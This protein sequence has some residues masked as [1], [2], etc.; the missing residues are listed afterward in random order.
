VTVYKLPATEALRRLHEFSAIIDAR[1]EG[2]F[3]LDH[4]PDALNWPVLTDE[5]RAAVGTMDRQVGSFEAKKRG[6]AMVARN[7]ARHIDTQVQDLRADWKPLVY[8]W[9]GGKRS[10]TL[11]WFLDQIGFQTHVIEGGYKAFRKALVDD[12]NVLPLKFEFRVVCGKT[13]SGKT[14][15][16]H[17]LERAGAQILDLEGLAHHRGSVL[18]II[19]GKHQPTQKAYDRA[20]WE[21][22]SA[23]DPAVPVFVESESKKV[24]NL[25]VPDTLMQRMR[26][27]GQ[28]LH[29]ELDDDNRVALLLEEYD[30]FRHDVPLFHQRLEAL[31]QIRGREV[32]DAWKAQSATGDFAGVYRDLML[33]HY[34]PVYLTS[35]TRNFKQFGSAMVV[36]PGHHGASAYDAAAREILQ[37]EAAGR[38]SL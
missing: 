5:E 38:I 35:I 19:P 16:L 23:L 27:H 8:C 18:G 7:V 4:L 3:A 22:L 33:N 20:I 24:G 13:G 11:A 2:E 37:F 15:L 32:V 6:A 10:G 29:I 1:S 30:F 25:A 12:L 28:C 21:H 31:V 14:R 34:D 17:A 9:R 36:T 26:E